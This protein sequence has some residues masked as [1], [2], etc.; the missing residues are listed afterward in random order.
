MLQKG[1]AYLSDGD[2]AHLAGFHKEQLEDEKW[3][4]NFDA[5]KIVDI[6]RHPLVWRGSTAF[7][8]ETCP[9]DT[10]A[11]V[12]KLQ[13]AIRAD[14]KWL[15]LSLL[16]LSA[17]CDA[18]LPCG[19]IRV[20]EVDKD[21]AEECFSAKRLFLRKGVAAWLKN[22]RYNADS[23]SS[24]WLNY[25]SDL[26]DTVENYGLK[27]IATKDAGWLFCIKNKNLKDEDMFRIKEKMKDLENN[28]LRIIEG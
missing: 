16:G 12:L 23:G 1:L 6:E 14:R 15:F 20:P 13:E 7:L 26:W 24:A 21:W 5:L 27:R 10:L 25:L 8:G 2:W 18:G 22:E 11:A 19:S 28:I 9:E 3:K 4:T 17:K